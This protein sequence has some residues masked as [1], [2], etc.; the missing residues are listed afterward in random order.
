MRFNCEFKNCKCRKYH[1]HSL[2]RIELINNICLN[3]N[4]AN[5]WHSRIESPPND[6]YLSFVSP[7]LSARKP[8]YIKKYIPIVFVLEVPPIPDS[9]EEIPYCECIEILPV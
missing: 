8:I 6:N 4:H 2:C 5:I 3:C 1:K 7:R 9:D